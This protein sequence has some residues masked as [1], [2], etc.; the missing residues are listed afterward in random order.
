MSRNTATN[1]KR[2]NRFAQ[3]PGSAIQ[4]SKFDRSFGYK[5]TFNGG[6]LIPIVFEEVLP[7]D[8]FDLNMTQFVRMNTLVS[9][10]SITSI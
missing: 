7:G 2:S 10:F 8:T 1:R 9:P 4:R 6:E 3:V 5:T